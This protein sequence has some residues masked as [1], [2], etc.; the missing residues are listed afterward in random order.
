MTD[1]PE[2]YKLAP[3]TPTKAM[4]EG[5]EDS[6]GYRFEVSRTL[7]GCYDTIGIPAN[8]CAQIYKAMLA[9]VK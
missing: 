5:M 1:I 4:L 3:I 2:G 6:L 7:G 8:I 9:L